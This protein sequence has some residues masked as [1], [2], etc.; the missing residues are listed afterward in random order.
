MA[1]SA[2]STDRQVPTSHFHFWALGKGVKYRA[3]STGYFDHDRD[4]ERKIEEAMKTTKFVVKLNRGGALAVQ[5]VQRI[6]RTPIQ[7]TTNRKLALIM[8]RFTAEDAAK[9]I[10]SARCTPE[11]IMVQIPA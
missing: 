11:L 7:T 3:A 8:G 4:I 1:R 9:S 6:D 10:Q 2:N 5:Y